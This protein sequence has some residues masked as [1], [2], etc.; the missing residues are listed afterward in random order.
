MVVKT[1]GVKY[2]SSR[3]SN[4]KEKMGFYINLQ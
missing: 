4:E 2:K 3:I 1:I